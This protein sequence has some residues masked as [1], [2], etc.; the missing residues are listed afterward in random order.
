ML[1]RKNRFHGYNSLRYTYQ[2]GDSVRGSLCVLKYSRNPRRTT[3][4]AAVVVSKKVSKSAVVRNRIRRRVYEVVRTMI[5]PN[6][7]YDL[8]FTVYSDR[9]AV[10]PIDELHAVIFDKLTAAHIAVSTVPTLTDH[11][12]VEPKEK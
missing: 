11:V 10:M 5:V 3:Y 8:I 2:H 1:T 4:R 7:P 12:I 9:L 6:Q